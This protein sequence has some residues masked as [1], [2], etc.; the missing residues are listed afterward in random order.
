MYVILPH[1]DIVNYLLKIDAIWHKLSQICFASNDI[2]KTKKLLYYLNNHLNDEHII[3][4]LTLIDEPKSKR[5]LFHLKQIS[6]DELANMEFFGINSNDLDI[7]GA[8]L[9]LQGDEFNEFKTS[10][11]TP[12]LDFLSIEGLINDGKQ[13]KKELQ[14]YHRKYFNEA[15]LNEIIAYMNDP[16]IV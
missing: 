14:E 1:N 15:S 7:I 9:K 11:L 4:A 13:T 16:N 12:T 10:M 5:N 6:I 8:I 2:Q 3:T